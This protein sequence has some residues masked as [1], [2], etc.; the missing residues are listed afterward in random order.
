MDVIREFDP[1]HDPLCTCPKKYGLNPYT[2]C[3]HG[4]LYCYITSYIPRAFEC[5]PKHNLIARIERDLKQIDRGRVIS[6][7]NSSDPYPPM[8]A[9]L[10]L[11]RSC[12]R[13][14]SRENCKVQVITKSNLVTRDLDLLSKMR[15]V[16]SFTI[17]TLDQELSQKLEPNA[18]SP[19]KRLEAMKRLSDAGVPVSLR[20][21]PVIPYLTNGGAV[22]VIKAA[23][24]HGVRHV[25]SSTFKPRPDSWRRIQ[26]AFPSIASKLRPLYFERGRRHH[27][28]WYLPQELRRRLMDEIRQACDGEGLT[29]ATCR[30]GLAKIGVGASCDGSHLI[31]QRFFSK[32]PVL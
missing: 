19:K 29:F 27:N 32:R 20:V 13:L 11:T 9:K 1:W 23:A 25:T 8:E 10:G 31:G 30:E 24:R 17:V 6:M 12:L 28:C 3:E 14:F 22:D 4:C 15:V 7:S 5:R 21:D 16:V 18:P 2:G 26:N